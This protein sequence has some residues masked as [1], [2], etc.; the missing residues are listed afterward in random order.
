[1]NIKKLIFTPPIL[2]GFFMGKMK[3]LIILLI[4]TI[5]FGSFTSYAD[6][7]IIK[8]K[9]G[10]ILIT[11]IP[12]PRY[13]KNANNIKIIKSKKKFSLVVPNKKIDYFLKKA[14]KL[15]NVD[16][17]LLKS[18]AKVESNFKHNVISRKG[19]IGLMQIMP[20]TAKRFG[21]RN[22]YNLKENIYGAAKY[23]KY[24]LKIFHNNIILA[25]AAYNAGENVVKKYQGIPPYK[26]T[27]NYVRQVLFYYKKLKFNEEI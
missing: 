17:Y 1:M 14:S 26:E 12:S 21:I 13:L 15:Y 11:N 10:T 25:T 2:G 18:I 6:I 16:Y 22:P 7:F 9:D 4:F 3:N 24:L 19:A 27:M 20:E 8:K 5:I 23:L